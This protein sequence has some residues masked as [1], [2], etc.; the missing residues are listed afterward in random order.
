LV[1]CDKTAVVPPPR[2]EF[3]PQVAC[4]MDRQV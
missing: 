2:G 1:A 4:D 3:G